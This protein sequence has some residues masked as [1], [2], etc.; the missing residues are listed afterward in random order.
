MLSNSLEDFSRQ[1][2]FQL[3]QATLLKWNDENS[4]NTSSLCNMIPRH[5]NGLCLNTVYNNTNP[6]LLWKHLLQL[7][8]AS[9][10][11]QI[12]RAKQ[13]KIRGRKVV[14]WNIM[15]FQFSNCPYFKHESFIG[16]SIDIKYNFIISMSLIRRYKCL[17]D[18]I[19]I[20]G[21][22]MT[23]KVDTGLSYKT[24]TILIIIS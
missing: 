24:M 16:I 14:W 17:R 10:L 2:S 20:E 5:A 7:Q 15:K 18:W 21:V 12:I 3:M 19:M 11:T 23:A 6:A 4:C 9:K 13:N 22:Y 1:H 8:I